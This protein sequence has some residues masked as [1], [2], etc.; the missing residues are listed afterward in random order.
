MKTN[1]SFLLVLLLI[2]CTDGSDLSDPEA[3]TATT[4]ASTTPV[5]N[6][7]VAEQPA[8]E[9]AT[10]SG[11]QE[12][13]TEPS[14]GEEVDTNPVHIE[15]IARTFEN[16]VSI[17]IVGTDGREVESTFTTARGE[18]GSFNPYSLNFWLTRDPGRDFSIQAVEY[19]AK[20]GT[21]R[22]LDTVAVKNN[23]EAIEVKLFFPRS[24]GDDCR[25][26]EP[27]TR[28]IPKSIAMA[29]L[30]VEALMRGPTENER[31]RGVIN[32]MPRGATLGSVSMDGST[33]V[34]DF[35][36][37]MSNVGGSCRAL[38]VR[39]SIETTLRALPTVTRVRILAAGDEATAL[40]P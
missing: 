8:D 1:R 15:G 29:R 24:D 25:R 27:V 5:A 7:N 26:V 14:E 16:N 30:L 13:I 31:T 17:R 9:P 3:S 36:S 20:D 35:S 22:L 21:P 6:T 40:Q 34:V 38:A 19:S 28:R 37:G 4:T 33:A 18:M 32:P 23:I 10:A 11:D 2:G 12:P 39:A